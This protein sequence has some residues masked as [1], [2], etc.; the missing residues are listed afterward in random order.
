M[1][2]EEDD[3]EILNKKRSLK[4]ILKNLLLIGLIATGVLFMYIGG[5]DQ[6]TNLIIGFTF[7][8]IGTTIFQMRKSPSDP[9]RQ[10]LTILKCKSCSAI[11]V[12]NYENGD[13]IFKSMG[14]C[15]KCNNSMEIHQI[16]S[17]KLKKSPKK[18]DKLEESKNKLTET[19]EV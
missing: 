2:D 15:D 8:C 4:S 16:Y 12:R 9:I 6:A 18:D 17:V 1:I 7:I 14:S 10:T 13:F 5:P 19:I 3:E 11:I